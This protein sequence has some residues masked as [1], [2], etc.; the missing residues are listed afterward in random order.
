MTFSRELV[1]AASRNYPNKTAFICGDRRATWAQM[2][3]RSD[4]LAK[5]LQGL[6]LKK[7]DAVSTLSQ[8]RIEVHEHLYACMKTG[9]IRI[10]VNARYV[11][12]EIEHILRDSKT[13]FLFVE[14]RCLPLIKDHFEEL[15]A[16]QIVLIGIGTKALAYEQ[17]AL[18]GAAEGE[19][20]WPAL[21]PDDPLFYSYTSGTTGFPKGVILTQQGVVD[22]ILFS[23]SSF[24]F[25]P[26]DIW[27]NPSASAWVTIVMSSFNLANGMTTVIP[28]GGFRIDQFLLDVGRFGVTSVILVPTMIQWIINE[29]SSK[30]Y[31][32]SSWRFLIYGSA[33][34]S[35]A[36]IRQM[37]EVLPVSLVQTYGLTE[38]TGGWATYLSE[39][40]HQEAL[41]RR[42]EWLKSVG[43]FAPHFECSIRDADGKPLPPNTQGEVWIR[44]TAVMKGYLNRPEETADVMREGG[45]LCTNDIAQ[46]DEDGLL[47]L[48][49][50]KKFMIISGAVNVFPSTV[51]AVLAEHVGIEEAAVIGAPHPEW[52]EAVVAFV[53]IKSSHAGLTGRNI[54]DFCADKLSKPE[55]PKHIVFVAELPK[56]SNGKI[57]KHT[58]REMLVR[59]P[60]ILPWSS[61]R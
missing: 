23:V 34:S 4:R 25:S 6:G 18:I 60:S 32:L 36:L 11:W 54:A 35:P 12:R 52:G 13:R 30:S 51:E 22:A 20:A 61:G 44:G 5:A 53:R 21:A 55:I 8:E 7:G 16:M 46:M 48:L 2:D 1:K 45:W 24:G 9:A 58:L 40:D 3:E 15:E 26:D 43:R 33:P 56:T 59:D 19:P 27:Y 57:M 10:G 41:A 38:I 28:D 37:R 17:E 42:P 39:K 49:D 29:L 47:Y 31:D 14:D 50:R